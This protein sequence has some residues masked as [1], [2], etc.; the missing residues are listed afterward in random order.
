MSSAIPS[1]QAKVMQFFKANSR[2]VMQKFRSL[3]NWET[4]AKEARNFSLMILALILT[5]IFFFAFKR[6]YGGFIFSTRPPL[7]VILYQDMLR[8]LGKSR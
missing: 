4:L 6:R 3:F 5:L 8:Q 2:N 1:N 7:S